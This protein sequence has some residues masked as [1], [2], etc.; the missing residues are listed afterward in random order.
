MLVWSRFTEY[1]CQI[2]VFLKYDSTFLKKLGINLHIFSNGR[3]RLFQMG[4]VVSSLLIKGQLCMI[5]KNRSLAVLKCY[6]S[7][8]SKT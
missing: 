4:T 3:D 6:G 2:I 1:I 8:V 5:Y 7:K